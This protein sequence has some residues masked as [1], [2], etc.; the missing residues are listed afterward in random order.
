M[1]WKKKCTIV[2]RFKRHTSMK[3]NKYAHGVCWF[4]FSFILVI[5]IRSHVCNVIQAIENC[6][7]RITGYKQFQ[8]FFFHFFLSLS[9]SMRL[10]LKILWNKNHTPNQ[11]TSVNAFLHFY[12]PLCPVSIV[13]L[14]ITAHCIFVRFFYFSSP[15]SSS[16]FAVT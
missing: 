12:L 6:F 11:T 15:S 7:E 9:V 16:S 10:F 13:L 14:F 1:T 5:A 2:V 8:Q 3:P 4:F